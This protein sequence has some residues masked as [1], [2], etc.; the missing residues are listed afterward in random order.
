MI[1]QQEH[2]WR[3]TAL[4]RRTQGQKTF[5]ETVSASCSMKGAGKIG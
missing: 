2:A 3:R 1:S 5:M 4:I